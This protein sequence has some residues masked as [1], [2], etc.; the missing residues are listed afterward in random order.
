MGVLLELDL[1]RFQ[2]GMFLLLELNLLRF[3]Q[4]VAELDDSSFNPGKFK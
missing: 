4:R 3:Q 1:L 2:D